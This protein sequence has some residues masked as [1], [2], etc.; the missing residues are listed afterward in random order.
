MS[1]TAVRTRCAL[2]AFVNCGPY[3]AL[4]QLGITCSDVRI[5]SL[6]VEV[7]FSLL[8]FWMHVALNGH[9]CLVTWSLTTAFFE[10]LICKNVH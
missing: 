5:T 6:V 8:D 1:T 4:D 3:T 2:D 9:Y 7:Y 10:F